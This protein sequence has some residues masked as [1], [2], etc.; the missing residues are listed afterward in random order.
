MKKIGDL[1]NTPR[2]TQQLGKKGPPH[3]LSAAVELIKDAGLFTKK[4]G[5]SYWL[6]KVKRAGV[7]YG[8]MHGILKEVGGM[9]KKYNKGGRL[10]NLLTERAK[11]LKEKKNG[12]H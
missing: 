5:W 3:E 11:A 9:D 8:E 4:Y 12:I 7:T 1:I 6:G 2:S 10:T